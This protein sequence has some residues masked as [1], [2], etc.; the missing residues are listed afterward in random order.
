MSK[1][2][3]SHSP[4][5]P[6]P[7]HWT[8][9]DREKQSFLIQVYSTFD[10]DEQMRRAQEGGTQFR[11]IVARNVLRAEVP[12]WLER[13]RREYREQGYDAERVTFMDGLG[14]YGYLLRDHDEGRAQLEIH[15]RLE[16]VPGEVYP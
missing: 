13:T 3:R 16:G 1:T 7:R 10:V 12:D 14:L 9:A 6:N 8:G 4:I 2:N 15:A 11:R 5:D